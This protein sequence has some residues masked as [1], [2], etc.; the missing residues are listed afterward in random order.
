MESLKLSE[1]DEVFTKLAYK[2]DGKTI[3]RKNLL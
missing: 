1:V 2:F 3:S